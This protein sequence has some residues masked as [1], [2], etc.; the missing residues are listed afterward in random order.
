MDNETLMALIPLLGTM[1]GTGGGILISSRLT[2][3]RIL[4]LEKKMDK[5]NNFIERIT[6]LE[7][8]SLNTCQAVGEIKSALKQLRERS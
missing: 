3:Y 2:Q 1:I 5:H 4:Q 6:R 8:T 7:G